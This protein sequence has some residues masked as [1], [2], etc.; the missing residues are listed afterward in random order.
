MSLV[1][2]LFRLLQRFQTKLD[3]PIEASYLVFWQYHLMLVSSDCI[4]LVDAN[5]RPEV[6]VL[7]YG[8]GWPRIYDV[9]FAFPLF[10]PLWGIYSTMH[11]DRRWTRFML[12]GRMAR[13]E[14]R[15]NQWRSLVMIYIHCQIALSTIWSHVYSNQC[16][17]NNISTIISTWCVITRITSRYMKLHF[18]K[19][20]LG[21]SQLPIC[22]IFFPK[23]SFSLSLFFHHLYFSSP[24]A[25]S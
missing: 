16:H 3:I 7:I 17:K 22:L 21:I 24:L 10:C 12:N 20:V 19:K 25:R 2:P 6:K 11:L 9:F 8:R 18:S 5:R 23:H 1:C 4:G 14:K 15:R 13:S